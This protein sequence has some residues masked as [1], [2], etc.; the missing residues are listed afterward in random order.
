MTSTSVAWVAALVLAAMALMLFIGVRAHRG[1]NRSAKERAPSRTFVPR[2]WPALESS[3]RVGC[4]H[5]GTPPL[6]LALDEQLP[7]DAEGYAVTSV[8][9]N[10]QLVHDTLTARMLGQRQRTLSVASVEG[11]ACQQ[12]A[13]DWRIVVNEAL[14]QLVYQRHGPGQWQLVHVGAGIFG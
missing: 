4:A 9:R 3:P 6:K 1:R 7:Q 11:W 12:P 2:L 14:R 5:A 13:L 10:G 8:Y